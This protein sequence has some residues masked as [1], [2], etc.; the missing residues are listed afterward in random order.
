MPN[1]SSNTRVAVIF[2]PEGRFRPVWFEL[3]HRR[4]DVRTITN[5]WRERRGETVR[6]H[7]HVTDDGALFE[8]IFNPDVATWQLLRI[9]AL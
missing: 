5:S 9:E 8:L 6:W 3:K 7:F 1:F 4:H 2:G